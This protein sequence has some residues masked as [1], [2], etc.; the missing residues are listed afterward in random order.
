MYMHYKVK[1]WFKIL[2]IIFKMKNEGHAMFQN[3]GRFSADL[4]WSVSLSQHK[5]GQTNRPFLCVG[6]EHSFHE[7]VIKSASSL[8]G[9]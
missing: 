2:E 8:V 4:C 9:V 3:L 1:D 5:L 6:Q 7:K